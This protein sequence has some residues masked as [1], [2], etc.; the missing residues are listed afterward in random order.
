MPPPNMA[1]WLT[2]YFKLK[3]LEKRHVQQGLSNLPL[4][5]VIKPF[6]EMCP[7]KTRRKG[8]SLYLRHQKESEQKPCFSPQSIA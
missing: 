1:T 4:Q 5:Q 3:K 7:V 8:A 6:C 2:E